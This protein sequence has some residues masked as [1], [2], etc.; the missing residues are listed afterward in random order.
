M[1]RSTKAPLVLRAENCLT[2]EMRIAYADPPYIG[3][4]KAMY[5]DHPDYKGEVDH[6]ALIRHLVTEYTDGWALSC[7]T[8]TL[9]F[10]LNTCATFGAED[11]RVS[12]WVKPWAVFKPGVSVAYAWEP[13]LWRGG[14]KRPRTKGT[15][16][17]WVSARAVMSTPGRV[18]TKGQKPE[19][20]CFWLFGL[21]NLEPGDELVDLYPGS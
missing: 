10:L 6:V 16:R 1:V 14:R 2:S 7:S 5:A 21:F 17:D 8:P 15:W 4:A 13:V 18:Q 19:T 3:R 11:V 20:F 9:R 12:A